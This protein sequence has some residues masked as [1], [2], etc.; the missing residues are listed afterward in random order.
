[1]VSLLGD[2][3][4]I[5]EIFMLVFGMIFF[6]YSEFIFNIDSIKKLFLARTK[7]K[8]MFIDENTPNK[9]LKNKDKYL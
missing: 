1:M 6:T 3:G 4:G 8:S 7:N 5:I 9:A 2:L